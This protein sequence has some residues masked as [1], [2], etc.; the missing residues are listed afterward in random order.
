MLNLQALRDAPSN[1]EPFPHG[2]APGMLS[3]EDI[4][5]VIRDYPDIDIGGLFLP[6]YASYGPAFAQLLAD[7]HSLELRDIIAEKLG[8]DLSGRPP[9]VTLRC[10]CQGKDG[11]IH[12]DSKF[13][14]ASVLLYLNEDWSDEG[15]K[16]RLLRSGNNIDDY[17]AELPPEAGVAVYFRVQPNA[18][19]GHKP[20]IGPRK[21]LMINYCASEESRARELARHRFSGKVKKLKRLFGI[22]RISRA[23]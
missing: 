14:L 11:R 15:G 22:G 17:F 10:N 13:K 20:F 9:M 23:A 18:W 6:E 4:A 12:V 19:H 21:Y 3:K 5:A 8:M 7:L 16:L 2:I 1:Q